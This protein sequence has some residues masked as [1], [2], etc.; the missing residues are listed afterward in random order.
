[1]P[2]DRR[3]R[4][5]GR[6]AP[7]PS[8][9]LHLGSLIAA[10]GSYLDAR[11][12]HGLWLLRIDDLDQARTPNG[13]SAGI[14]EQLHAHGLA[15]DQKPILQSEQNHR[16]E[17]AL[18]QLANQGLVYRCSCTRKQLNA[19]LKTHPEING[20]YGI[21]YP[22]FCRKRTLADAQQAAW[23]LITPDKTLSQAD[24]FGA[25][26]TINPARELGDVIVRR[27]DGPFAYHLANVVDD[28][29]TGV[30]DVVRGE[31][32]KPF[33]P[34]H[35]W[36]TKQLEPDYPD[37]RYGHLPLVFGPDGRKLSKTN[38]ARPLDNRQARANLCAAARYL[39]LRCPDQAGINALLDIW[40]EIWGARLSK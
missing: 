2:S 6:F 27:R 20:T 34:L 37:I 8:G 4:Y 1:M 35:Q 16:Y 11:A 28:L 21:I 12:H 32:L 13:V 39:K 40:T 31:D 14:I 36:L 9:L 29:H 18:A 17:Q 10:L 30:T 24:R 23:R 3:Q 7:T 33:A 38:H 25:E 19:Q 22:G 15:F 5:I 26:S